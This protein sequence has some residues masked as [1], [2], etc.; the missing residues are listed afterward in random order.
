MWGITFFQKD[1]TNFPHISPWGSYFLSASRAPPPPPIHRPSSIITFYYHSRTFI[2]TPSLSHNHQQTI[3]ITQ[4]SAQ[5]H[6]HTNINALWLPDVNTLSWSYWRQHKITIAQSCLSTFFL[7]L[8][9]WFSFLFWRVW[10]LFWWWRKALE[11]L[12]R[13]FC[14]SH[15]RLLGVKIGVGNVQE[16]TVNYRTNCFLRMF[17]GM[18]SRKKTRFSCMGT[19][20]LNFWCYVACSLWDVWCA[21]NTVHTVKKLPSEQCRNI[22]SRERLSAGFFQ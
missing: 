10:D 16:N 2:I 20:F 17:V 22:F 1:L 21:K 5:H 4:T 8:S 15:G 9:I 18:H 11:T 12:R 3:T 19:Q 13:F 14:G 6:C 7:S